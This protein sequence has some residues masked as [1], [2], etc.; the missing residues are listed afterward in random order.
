[1]YSLAIFLV[2]MFSL[3]LQSVHISITKY[4]IYKALSILN[5]KCLVIVLMA[6]QKF[7]KQQLYL[8]FA[9]L[10]CI[11]NCWKSKYLA[12]ITVIPSKTC[13]AFTLELLGLSHLKI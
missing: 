3:L 1:V 6:L 10:F 5:Y 7:T 12:A 8:M 11:N 13:L 2:C 4:I 9:F